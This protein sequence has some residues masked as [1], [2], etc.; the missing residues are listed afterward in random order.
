[1]A[2]RLA[3]VSIGS[4]VVGSGAATGGGMYGYWDESDMSNKPSD[5]NYGLAENQKD[6]TL[7]THRPLRWL[8]SPDIKHY[9]YKV[10]V[11][12]AGQGL[13]DYKNNLTS[14]EMK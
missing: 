4:G 12:M 5:I 10:D 8:G 11:D 2:G 13:E 6:L 7:G 1:M 9:N 3:G 14:G